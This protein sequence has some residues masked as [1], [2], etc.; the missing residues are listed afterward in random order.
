MVT[1][2]LLSVLLDEKFKSQGLRRYAA[3]PGRVAQVG[4]LSYTL[5]G[6]GF[7]SGSGH[8][9]RWWVPSPVRARK[10][11]NSLSVSQIN[12]HVR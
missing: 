4:T 1:Q 10:G 12:K 5:E 7:D 6:C 3:G 2:I 9:P 8:I 11:G